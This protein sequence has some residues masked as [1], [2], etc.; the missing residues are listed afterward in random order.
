MSPGNISHPCWLTDCNI[1]HLGLL[2]EVFRNSLFKLSN[3]AKK[4][5]KFLTLSSKGSKYKVKLFQD[6][7]IKIH[8]RDLKFWQH[9]ANEMK[10]R[11]L[12]ITFMAL[13]WNT[14]VITKKLAEK[15]ELIKVSIVSRKFRGQKEVSE[16][17]YSFYF[18]SFFT[19]EVKWSKSTECPY[20]YRTNYF[21][22]AGQLSRMSSF[23]P[24]YP[25]F[26]KS[27]YKCET[28]ESLWFAILVTNLFFVSFIS[29]F[30]RN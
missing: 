24:T 23:Q 17:L 11:N 14:L 25:I 20:L 1:S 28:E 9:Q 26:G 19:L 3:L 29:W 5:T 8:L 12:E 2:I 18:H 15:V 16:H 22:F 7:N 13:M 27:N 6:E 10:S 30:V 21:I 4:S